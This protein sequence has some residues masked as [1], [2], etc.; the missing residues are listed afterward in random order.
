MHEQLDREL[1]Q[2]IFESRVIHIT[3]LTEELHLLRM[4]MGAALFLL[5][6]CACE[7]EQSAREEKGAED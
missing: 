1:D 3:R 2:E 7:R 6:E 4:V 5:E